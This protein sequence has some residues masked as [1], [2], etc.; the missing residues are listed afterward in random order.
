LIKVFFEIFLRVDPEVWTIF[1][2][3]FLWVCCFSNLFPL[4]L[5]QVVHIAS[6]SHERLRDPWQCSVINAFPLALSIVIRLKP[7][8][9]SF[10]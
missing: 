4:R 3:P 9:C 2:T 6:P 8:V 5:S 1:P 10:P 7:L